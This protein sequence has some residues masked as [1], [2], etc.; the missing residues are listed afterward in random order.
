MSSSP[1]RR[2]VWSGAALLAIA[3]VLGATVM[4]AF[5]NAPLPL[6]TWWEGALPDDRT[7]PLLAISLVLDTVGRGLF[8]RLW[9]PLGI[10][11]LLVLLR[12]PWAAAY[13][14]AAELVSFAVVQ[15]LKALIDRPRPEDVLV[16]VDVGAYPSGHVGNAA[17]LAV[18]AWVIFPRWLVAV[19]ALAWIAAM[20]FSRTY[21][22]AHWLTD[23]VGGALVGAGVA[24]LVAVP[25]ARVLDPGAGPV[26]SSGP[27]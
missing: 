2:W 11:A 27:G 18:A 10:A 8:A 12:R 6:D 15:L 21:L 23:T 25:F 14:F 17:A 9:V 3:A 22:G 24:L 20:A 4:L 13:V 26:R 1:R 5:G 16:A 7:G 19:P